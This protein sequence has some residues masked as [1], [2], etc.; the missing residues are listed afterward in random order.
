MSKDSFKAITEQ[1]R[2]VIWLY[3]TVLDSQE[4]SN[5]LSNNII[6]AW[7]YVQYRYA[8]FAWAGTIRC[9]FTLI[10]FTYVWGVS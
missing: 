2:R 4:I 10:T 3:C 8:F 1:Y 6:Y 9:C 5:E 7:G